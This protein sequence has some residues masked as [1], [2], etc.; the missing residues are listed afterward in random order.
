MEKQQKRAVVLVSGGM[1]SAVVL[2]LAR[3]QES[4]AA[5]PDTTVLPLLERVVVEQSPW[6]EG[7]P[8]E[9]SVNVATD[10]G[11]TLPAPVLQVLLANLVGNAFAHTHR[12]TQNGQVKAAPQQVHQHGTG[13]VCV[14]HKQ[15]KQPEQ[16]PKQ[17][18]QQQN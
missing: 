16:E 1:D 15:A 4:P 9:V 7:K 8:V 14:Q 17:V 18:D 12:G 11:S 10:L 3:E 2:A 5:V 6:L 13:F